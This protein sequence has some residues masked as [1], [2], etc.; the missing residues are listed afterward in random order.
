M[1]TETRHSQ[2]NTLDL[3]HI[4]PEPISATWQDMCSCEHS[5]GPS[6]KPQNS[7]CLPFALHSK[8]CYAFT[9]TTLYVIHQVPE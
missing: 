8:S 9:S 2:S 1:G 4:V 7:I 5:G 6:K 3:A